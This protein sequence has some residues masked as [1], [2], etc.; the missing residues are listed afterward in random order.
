VGKGESTGLATASVDWFAMGSSFN[1][2]E[3]EAT[4][5][6]AH[7]VLKK[8]G[9]FS[10]LWNNRDLN[11][12]I[13]REVEEIIRSFVPSYLHGTRREQ[14]ADVILQSRLFNDVHYYEHAQSVQ[15]DVKDYI[16]AWRS[17]KNSYW[18]LSTAS[19][20][21]LFESIFAEV[22]RRLKTKQSLEL[23]YITRTWTARRID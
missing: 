5:R 20:R 1:T 21:E 19:G 15:R 22:H 18:D 8:G 3:R 17:V 9:Y 12:P 13:Q 11:D 16:E 2:T 23:Q 7:R 14:Q 6:E 10:C 4:L